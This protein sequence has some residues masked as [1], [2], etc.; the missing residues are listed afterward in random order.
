MAKEQR[1]FTKEFKLEAVRLAETSGKPITELARELG[2]SDSTIHNWRKQLAEQGSDA[3]PG[4]GH[5]TPIEEENRRLKRELEIVKQERDILKRA[6]FWRTAPR[7]N[8][9]IMGGK[10]AN[11]RT[12]LFA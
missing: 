10:D 11:A 4:S 12:E 1:T 7:M 5:Q 2:V 8:R 3:F 9:G 6:M